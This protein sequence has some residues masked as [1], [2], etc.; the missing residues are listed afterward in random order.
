MTVITIGKRLIPV[1]QIAVIEPYDPAANPR[2]KT[3][4]QF[5]ARVMLIDR[6]SVLTEDT[7]EAFA[8][9]NGFR[10]LAEDRIALNPAVAFFVET[11]EPTE[12]FQPTKPYATRLRW[13]DRDGEI[14][15]KL[16]LTKP[17]TVLA[18]A[19]KGE[20]DPGSAA[21]SVATRTSRRRRAA[22]APS[23]A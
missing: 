12:G 8:E 3:E 23:T 22:P 14:Q 1:E 19:V 18:V 5:Q 6:D 2:I 21:P 7:P 10:M 15:S 17:E 16:L 13:R 11:F 20:R 4:R 9:A